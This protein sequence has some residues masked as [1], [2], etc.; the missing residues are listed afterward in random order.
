MIPQEAN[1]LDVTLENVT[2]EQFPNLAGGTI[3]RLVMAAFPTVEV[4]NLE[5][6]MWAVRS[7]GTS[8]KASYYLYLQPT[9]DGTQFSGRVDSVWNGMDARE[10]WG[11][12]A[13]DVT[14]RA[15][16]DAWCMV[17]H[18]EKGWAYIDHTGEE[19]ITDA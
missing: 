12:D 2:S 5:R 14:Q 10:Y 7:L 8:W 19:R 6:M 18:Y 13:L 16:L 15:I 17:K 3:L 9:G 4:M 11:K 1:E